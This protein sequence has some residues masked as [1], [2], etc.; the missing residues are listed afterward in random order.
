[1][2]IIKIYLKKRIISILIHI[3]LLLQKCLDFQILNKNDY[4]NQFFLDFLLI[5]ELRLGSVINNA[6]KF[7]LDFLLINELHLDFLIN[8]SN[9]F[10][11]DLL[12]INELHLH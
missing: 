2:Y 1:M 7:Y 12:L 4:P 6:K 5:N 9:L 8:L 11:L 10:F 3:I